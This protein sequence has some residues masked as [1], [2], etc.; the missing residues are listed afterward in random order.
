MI[1][2]SYGLTFDE[3]GTTGSRL[4]LKLID[5]DEIPMEA[6]VDLADD[7]NRTVY[8]ARVLYINMA[9]FKNMNS[10]DNHG[11]SEEIGKNFEYNNKQRL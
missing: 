11:F 6:C 7:G 9:Y 10:D 3:K 4:K 5:D 8:E 1:K 2:E